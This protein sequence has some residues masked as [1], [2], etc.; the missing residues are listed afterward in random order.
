MLN[1]DVPNGMKDSLS[2]EESKTSGFVYIIMFDT[3]RIQ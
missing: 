2:H 1:I 3:K